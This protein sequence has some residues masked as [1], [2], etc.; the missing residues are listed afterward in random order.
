SIFGV[1]GA[2]GV[3]SITTRSGISPDIPRETK[4][5]IA[6]IEP[7]GYQKPVEFYAPK[8][9]TPELKGY[10]IPD[11]RTTI[12]WKPDLF[13]SYDGKA[14][15]EFYTSDSPTTYSVVIEGISDDDRIIRQVE[16]I[17]IR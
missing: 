4:K 16:R 10:D 17:K 8:Y 7:L 5:N 2:G 14:S 1:Q 6:I 13:V 11:Y 12:F 15:F 9:D 3:I